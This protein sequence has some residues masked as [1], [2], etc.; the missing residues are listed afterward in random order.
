MF[1]NNE[2]FTIHLSDQPCSQENRPD[3]NESVEFKDTIGDQVQDFIVHS[4]PKN[5]FLPLV[6]KNLIKHDLIDADLF[7]VNFPAIHVADFCAFINN[8]FGG[9]SS[10]SKNNKTNGLLLKLCKF[11][12]TKHIKFPLICIKNPVARQALV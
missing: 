10:S 1:V 11:I 5:K 2:R 6:F 12:R 3:L 4:Y 9:G 7:F 8:S